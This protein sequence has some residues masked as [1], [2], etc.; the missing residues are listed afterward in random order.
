[1]KVESPQKEK[2]KEKRVS[3]CV[4]EFFQQICLWNYLLNN[5]QATQTHIWIPSKSI[6]TFY[7]FLLL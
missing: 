3:K 6:A 5:K 2:R 4:Q 1:M 7:E